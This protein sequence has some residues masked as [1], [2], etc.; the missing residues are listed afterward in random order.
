M[1]G[2]IVWMTTQNKITNF[3]LWWLYR[4]N[5][6]RVFLKLD[7]RK[8]FDEMS[9]GKIFIKQEKT[10]ISGRN[11]GVW[12][13][14]GSSWAKWSW[15]WLHSWKISVNNSRHI[16]SHNKLKTGLSYD[17]CWGMSLVKMSISILRGKHLRHSRTGVVEMESN[18]LSTKVASA[19]TYRLETRS[20]SL[21]WEL[22]SQ[23]WQTG[24]KAWGLFME[25]RMTEPWWKV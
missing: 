4:L 13:L 14:N 22:I 16:F 25:D 20:F 5:K 9:C 3:L 2:G 15:P 18:C 10:E 11:M 23:W 19:C 21:S 6:C 24:E 12:I 7:M 17:I 1:I 8:A